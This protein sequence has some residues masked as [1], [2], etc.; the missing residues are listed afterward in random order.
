MLL[1]PGSVLLPALCVL[2]VRDFSSVYGVKSSEFGLFNLLGLPHRR[3]TEVAWG[4]PEGPVGSLLSGF[5]LSLRG[6]CG[7]CL[8]K[9][10]EA[11]SRVSG[12]K[13]SLFSLNFA[14]SCLR[15]QLQFSFIS[16]NLT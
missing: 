2:A 9:P 11:A 3:P 4:G 1:E 5:S 15:V 16:Q 10:W 8:F 6:F 12:F 7:P 13:Q 14:A